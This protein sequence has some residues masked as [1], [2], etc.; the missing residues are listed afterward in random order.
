MIASYAGTS[1]GDDQVPHD[2]PNASERDHCRLRLRA[3]I[4]ARGCHRDGGGAAAATEGGAAAARESPAGSAIDVEGSRTRPRKG[5]IDDDPQQEKDKNFGKW[6]DDEHERFCEAWSC[7]G[8]SGP[9]SRIS[10]NHARASRS[11]RTPK[12]IFLGIPSRAKKGVRWR[13]RRSP[14]LRDSVD[15]RSPSSTAVLQGDINAPL[16]SA[17]LIRCAK[18]P[19]RWRT[20]LPVPTLRKRQRLVPRPLKFPEEERTPRADWVGKI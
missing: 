20:R 10:C 12:S 14:R 4:A 16:S 17:R 11:A 15:D 8:E 13:P 9:R 18:T 19:E 6:T 5:N 1:H 7:T 3:P 2:P